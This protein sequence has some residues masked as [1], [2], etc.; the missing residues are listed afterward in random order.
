MELRSENRTKDKHKNANQHKENKK[1][2]TTKHENETQIQS[3]PRNT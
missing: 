1:I 3:E 2:H